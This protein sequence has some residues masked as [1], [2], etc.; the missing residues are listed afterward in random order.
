M[1][2]IVY[3]N[4]SS[5]NEDLGLKTILLANVPVQHSCNSIITFFL[6][7]LSNFTA[8]TL[9]EVNYFILCLAKLMLATIMKDGHKLY[10]KPKMEQKMPSS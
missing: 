6:V 2:L 7:S 4:F 8:G 10:S 9:C 5:A 3:S 1:Y